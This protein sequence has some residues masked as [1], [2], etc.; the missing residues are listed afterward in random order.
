MQSHEIYEK[1]EIKHAMFTKILVIY[2]IVSVA[3][4]YMLSALFPIMYAMFG[5]P[6]PEQ[7]SLPLEIQ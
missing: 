2:S 7:W 1:A 4:L 3:S 6:P 5:S